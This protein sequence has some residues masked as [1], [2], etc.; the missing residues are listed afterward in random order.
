MLAVLLWGAGSLLAGQMKLDT[1]TVGPVTYTNVT[2]LGANTTDLYFTHQAGIGN[3]K[4][5]YL[6][7]ALQ[8]Q[9]NY[10]PRAAAAAERQRAEDDARYQ[11]EIAADAGRA[12][13]AAGPNGNPDE[14]AEVRLADP[15]GDHSPLGKAAP[16]MNVEK[17]LGDKPALDGKF[18][19][20]CFWKPESA[21]CRKWIP[22]L[23]ALQKEFTNQLAVVGLC[24]ASETAVT[25]MESPKI[26]FAS[27]LDSKAKLGS[28]VGVTSVPTVLLVDPKGTVRYLGHPAAVTPAALQALLPKGAETP[29]EGSAKQ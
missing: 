17:W 6:S 19:L 7:S 14:A 5:K 27:A 24:A 11:R 21:A 26:E 13:A 23:N 12:R 1:L 3:V 8:K 25:S 10:D 15:I 22:E 2:V 28:A 20:V 4:L 18:V 16:A 29:A 9:F